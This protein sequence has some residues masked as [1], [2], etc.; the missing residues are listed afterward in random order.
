MFENFVYGWVAREHNEVHGRGG[1]RHEIS[2]ARFR[3]ESGLEE[4]EGVEERCGIGCYIDKNTPPKPWPR[5]EDPQPESAHTSD[6]QR[7]HIEVGDFGELQDISWTPIVLRAR[8]DNILEN[9]IQ[10]FDGEVVDTCLH[11]AVQGSESVF[12]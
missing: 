9:D 1:R 4:V 7:K 12:L 3:R 11:S 8:D 10:Q 5:F 6:I 2:G